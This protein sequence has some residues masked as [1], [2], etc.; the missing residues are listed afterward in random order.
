MSNDE[1]AIRQLVEDWFAA[2]KNGDTKTILGLMTDDVVFTVAGQ[3]P[4]G[5]EAF[6]AAA[7]QQQNMNIDGTYDIKEIKI[8]DDWA[9]LR[10][11]IKIKMSVG[12][13]EPVNRSGYTLTILC[14]GADG[15]WRITR[16]ANLLT[17]DK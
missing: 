11:F 6:E 15:K 9:Y 4:F 3:E 2:T 7:N 16:D 5:K 1:Q 8:I 14:K 17:I 13:G 12:G 10:N